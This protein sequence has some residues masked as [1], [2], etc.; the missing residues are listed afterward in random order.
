MGK[1]IDLDGSHIYEKESQSFR[2]KVIIVTSAAKKG[3]SPSKQPVPSNNTTTGSS[4]CP[5]S[6]KRSVYTVHC[7]LRGAKKTKGCLQKIK[8]VFGNEESPSASAQDLIV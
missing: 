2:S 1:N 5:N 4:V 6:T 8:R 7:S 3:T